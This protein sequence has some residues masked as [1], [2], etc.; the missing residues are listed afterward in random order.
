MLERI[1]EI[2]P[3]FDRRHADPSKNYGVHGCDLRMVVKG[4]KG[5]M[6]FVL[7]TGWMLPHVAEEFTSKGFRMEPLPADVGYHSPVPMY[8][9]QAP[10]GECPF[11]DGHICYYDGSGLYAEKAFKVLLEGGS[12]A[13]WKFLENEYVERFGGDAT[14]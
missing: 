3:A 11:V 4:K 13:L 1:I 5:A 9:N 14:T 2:T 10:M 8:E 6:Q 7:Y 12:D